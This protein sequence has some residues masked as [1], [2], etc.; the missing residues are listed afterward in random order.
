M[1]TFFS[2]Q[3]N[4]GLGI[5]QVMVYERRGSKISHLHITCMGTELMKPFVLVNLSSGNA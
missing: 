2:L 3:V 4:E 1:G 5:S